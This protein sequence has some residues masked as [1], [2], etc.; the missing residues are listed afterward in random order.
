MWPE[1][2]R[3]VLEKCWTTCI[4]F[5][6]QRPVTSIHWGAIKA[7]KGDCIAPEPKA[8]TLFHEAATD[9]RRPQHVKC[10]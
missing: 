3:P 6:Q 10:Q 5:V 1:N 4:N 9:I 7:S 2:M 8:N